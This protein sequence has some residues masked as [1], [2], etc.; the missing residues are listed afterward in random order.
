MAQLD[1]SKVARTNGKRVVT[2]A[3]RRLQS[4]V[5]MEMVSVSDMA[6]FLDLA[7]CDFVQVATEYREL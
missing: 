4:G 1:D 6:K 2:I 3:S 7:Y 5:E